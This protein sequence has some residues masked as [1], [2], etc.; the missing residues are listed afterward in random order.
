MEKKEDSD[1]SDFYISS[2]HSFPFISFIR[3]TRFMTN[4]PVDLCEKKNDKERER[5][6]KLRWEKKVD[7]YGGDRKD[8]WLAHHLLGTDD[9]LV[10]RIRKQN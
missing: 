4:Y 5:E 2:N 3:F 6:I 8:R 10:L 9:G 7:E 1:P